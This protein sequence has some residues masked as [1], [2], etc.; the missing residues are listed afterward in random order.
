MV[1]DLLREMSTMDV[2]SDTFEGK[3]A[4]LKSSVHDHFQD[5]ESEMFT[6]MKQRMSQAQLEELGKRL[7]NRNKELRAKVAA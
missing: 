3:L 4:Q 6:L 1:K 2:A 7:H 5:E